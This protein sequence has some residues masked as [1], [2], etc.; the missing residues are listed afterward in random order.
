MVYY[1]VCCSYN[2]LV[3]KVRA[4]L[5]CFF[6]F[7][8][9]NSSSVTKLKVH[10]GNSGFFGRVEPWPSPMKTINLLPKFTLGDFSSAWTNTRQCWGNWAMKA[11]DTCNWMWPCCVGGSALVPGQTHP[12]DNLR[13][14]SPNWFT[15]MLPRCLLQ[16]IEPHVIWGAWGKLGGIWCKT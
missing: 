3:S 15:P 9:L 8:A 5:R 11:R 4:H 2:P 6:F 10:M 12:I 7:I 13:I 1:G 14:C 16:P